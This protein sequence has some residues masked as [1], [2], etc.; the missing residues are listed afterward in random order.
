MKKLLTILSF[1]AA[2][3]VDGQIS[4]AEIK[5]EWKDI[6]PCFYE[7]YKSRKD[8]ELKYLFPSSCA[9][10]ILYVR[11]SDDGKSRKIIYWPMFKSTDLK[12]PTETKPGQVLEM[13]FRIKGGTLY[14]YGILEN[15]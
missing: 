3:Q 11:I 7:A 6:K 1:I 15:L 5:H 12:L 10:N 8:I 9:L 13:M 4:I 14:L 2:T